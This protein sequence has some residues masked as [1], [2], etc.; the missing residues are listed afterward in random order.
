M[1]F[2]SQNAGSKSNPLRRVLTLTTGLWPGG[3]GSQSGHPKWSRSILPWTLWS[4]DPTE[5]AWGIYLDFFC[6]I[7]IQ[8]ERFA[9]CEFWDVRSKQE[10]PT[11]F[12]TVGKYDLTLYSCQSGWAVL[13]K[14]YVLLL[15][16]WFLHGC[17]WVRK[18]CAQ[19]LTR[20]KHSSNCRTENPIWLDLVGENWKMHLW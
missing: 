14:F 1:F 18:Q 15:E 7:I 3:W 19:W 11:T 12:G 20:K 5:N 17:H 13:M 16:P 4:S 10:Y 8:N 9:V 6:S 2:F